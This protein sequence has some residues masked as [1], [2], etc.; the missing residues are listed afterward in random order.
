[1]APSRKPAAARKPYRT[2]SRA[3]SGGAARVLIGVLVGCVLTVCG[4]VAYFYVGRP[5]VAVADH[6][7][8][9]EHFL[10]AVPLERRASSEAKTPP[11]A[12]DEDAFE[13]AAHL[14]RSECAQCHGTPGHE[15]ALG[16]GMSPHA[17]QFFSI[18]DRSATQQTAGELF[19]ETAFGIRRSGMPAYNRTLTNSQLWQLSLMLH[20]ATNLPDPVRNILTANTQPSTPIQPN[21]F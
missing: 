7:A 3:G 19:W 15:A 14:Y 5:P 1:M 9:W 11:F 4:I 10:N 16:R 8:Q 18:R 2:S 21:P 12:A 6:S 17:P 20:S 13:S